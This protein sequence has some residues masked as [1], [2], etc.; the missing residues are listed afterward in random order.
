LVHKAN[1]S[2]VISM[3]GRPSALRRLCNS[4]RAIDISQHYHAGFGG[5]AC[6]RDQPT[7]MATGRLKPAHHISQ[8][9]WRLN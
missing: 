6:K 8:R 1:G 7:A 2:Y 4:V 5:H 3:N 9:R